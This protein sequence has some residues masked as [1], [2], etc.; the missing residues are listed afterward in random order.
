MFA[1]GN[2]KRPPTGTQAA[3]RL[4]APGAPREQYSTNYFRSTPALIQ[5]AISIWSGLESFGS[6]LKPEISL[7]K[8]KK[9]KKIKVYT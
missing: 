1:S 7:E 5:H 3:G 4:M 6:A 8:K 9:Q 2:Q